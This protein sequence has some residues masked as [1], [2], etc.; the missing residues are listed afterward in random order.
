M[1]PYIHS[2]LICDSQRL[3]LTQMYHSGRMD[4]KN[5]VHLHNGILL[6]Y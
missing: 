6:S 1:L 2:N 5:V 4:T 3:E